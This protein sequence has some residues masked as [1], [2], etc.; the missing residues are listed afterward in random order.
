MTY[1]SH[2]APLSHKSVAAVIAELIDAANIAAQKV[3]ERRKAKARLSKLSDRYL[4]D[5]GLTEHDVPDAT[6]MQLPS[7]GALELI[8]IRRSRSANW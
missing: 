6:R 8:D 1:T 7:G 5:I 3:I 2:T 4:R